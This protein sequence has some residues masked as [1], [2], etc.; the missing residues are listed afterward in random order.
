MGATVEKQ[1]HITSPVVPGTESA[2]VR[3]RAAHLFSHEPTLVLML[4]GPRAQLKAYD[5]SIIRALERVP[6]VSIVPPSFVDNPNSLRPF[7]EA[8]VMLVGTDGSFEDVGKRTVPEIRSILKRVVPP[9]IH[10]YLTGYAAIGTGIAQESFAALKRAELIAA[11]LL[12]ML[13]LLIFRSPI[14]AGIP[15]LLG[16]GSVLGARGVLAGVNAGV[17][18]LDA[19]ALNLASMFGLALGVD[20]SLL[21]VSRFREQLA[22][23]ESPA[24]AARNAGARAGQTVIIAGTALAAGMIAGY[25]VAPG[26]ILSSGCVGGVVGVLMGGIGA[27]VALPALLALLGEQVNRWSFRIDGAGERVAALAWHMIKRPI[28]VSGVVAVAMLALASQALSVKVSAPSVGSLPSSSV[29]RQ[30]LQAVSDRLGEGYVT[31]YEVVVDAREGRVTT[32]ILSATAAWQT[33]LG[34]DRAVAATRGPRTFQRVGLGLLGGAP[35]ELQGA[36]DMAINLDRG[37]TALRMEVIENTTRGVSRPG[38]SAAAPGDPLRER[39]LNGARELEAKTGAEVLVGGPAAYL[40]D[41]TS[42]S[43]NRLLPLVAVLSI[44]TFAILFFAM[45]SILV[46][47][48][49]VGLNILTVGA[50]LGVLVLGFQRTGLLGGAGTLDAIATPAVI[51]VAFGLAID[52]EVFL[53]AR[54]REGVTLTNDLDLGLRYALRK[55]AGV[56]TG[57]ALIMSGV[58]VAFGSNDLIN[59][60][61]FGVGLTVA[62]LIDATVVRLVL[63]PTGIRLLG[64]RAWRA[65]L[66]SDGPVSRW[67][68]EERPIS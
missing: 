27:V 30:N 56:I 55:T 64:T 35:P 6:H 7:D 3:A 11:P 34:E 62:V 18:P 58:F 48:V 24:E 40:E 17:L 54:V 47:L 66:L 37:G 5:P 15:L 26:R 38:G 59:L 67:R 28:L 42:S 16:I 13:L 31:P 19:S 44:V 36:V 10:H 51:S 43:E 52:Y 4:V 61:E 41:F 33:K 23:G 21:L 14:A 63:L 9:T 53:L 49:A 22:S 32:G 45:R 60:R 57:A 12:F 29:E 2:H 20:Y 68:S 1:L 65:T 39:L 50:S 8:G 46:A 25:F